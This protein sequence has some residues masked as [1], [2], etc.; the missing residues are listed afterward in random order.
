VCIYSKR[1]RALT[2]GHPCQDEAPDTE[3]RSCWSLFLEGVFGIKKGSGKLMI[4][5]FN[6]CVCVCGCVRERECV[7]IA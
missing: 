7:C 2:F 3:A 4:N 6:V 5:E 1:T